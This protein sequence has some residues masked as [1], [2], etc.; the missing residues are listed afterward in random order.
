LVS[1]LRK[2]WDSVVDPVVRALGESVQS[3]SRIWWCP[4][5]KFT[6]LSLHAA[7]PFEKN[8]EDDS[9]FLEMRCLLPSVK[10]TQTGKELSV[11]RPS[12][13]PSNDSRTAMQ[14]FRM[15]SMH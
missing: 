8:R 10:Q 6:L 15:H 3:R 9:G 4:T 14:Q 1:I 13:R 2:L 7:G 11:S 12:C 5:A